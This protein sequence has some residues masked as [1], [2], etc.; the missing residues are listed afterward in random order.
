[1]AHNF[2]G[3][4]AAPPTT[5][6]TP[7]IEGRAPT[8]PV[9]RRVRLNLPPKA[10]WWYKWHP[11]RWVVMDGEILPMLG[12]LTGEP[13]VNGTN[14]NG[15]TV[16][17]EINA[18]RR[19]WTVI[20]WDAV[21]GGYVRVYDGRR[22][23]V[24]LSRWETPKQ[25]ANRTLIK[26]DLEGY[27]VFL[28]QL[29]ADG[30]IPPPDPDILDAM[31]EGH[32]SSISRQSAKARTDPTIAAAVERDTETLETLEAAVNGVAAPKRKRKRKQK[33]IADAP[34]G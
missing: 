23:P 14:K 6:T 21:A 33:Q 28:R 18:R 8:M 12:R 31:A 17:A 19:G 15:D 13:G 20:P 9:S 3:G 26:S 32:R 29:M 5:S 11:A 30:I 4:A 27:K 16:G 1:M 22:G 2:T 7:T 24:H 34:N 25:I 10:R